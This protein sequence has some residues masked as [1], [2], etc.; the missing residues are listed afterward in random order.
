MSLYLFLLSLKTRDDHLGRVILFFDTTTPAIAP[1]T[2]VQAPTVAH[3]S[4]GYDGWVD[5]QATR[6]RELP[7]RMKY[8]SEV[9]D[10]LNTLYGVSKWTSTIS[11]LRDE[12]IS[13]TSRHVD[14]VPTGFITVHYSLLSPD[15]T[16]SVSMIEDIGV[17]I[18]PRMTIT[19]LHVSISLSLCDW[20][21]ISSAMTTK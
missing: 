4:P 12:Y 1:P 8:S 20:F 18:I 13:K 21:F 2:F 10:Q 5:E 9:L 11:K 17:R 14:A 7:I 15:L 3:Q 19:H 16:E 6:L